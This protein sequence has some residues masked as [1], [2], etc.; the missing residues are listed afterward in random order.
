[1]SVLSFVCRCAVQP[2]CWWEVVE[3]KQQQITQQQQQ[4]LTDKDR[5]EQ[6]GEAAAAAAE[7]G[8]SYAVQLV[9]N[10]VSTQ[11]PS[12]LNVHCRCTWSQSMC[13]IPSAVFNCPYLTTDH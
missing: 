12:A 3:Q 1:M 7:A 11:W 8:P 2:R 5:D 13:G 10:R 4:Q 6:P 9:T